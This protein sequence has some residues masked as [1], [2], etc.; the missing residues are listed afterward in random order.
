MTSVSIAIKNADGSEWSSTAATGKPAC[1]KADFEI[2]Q[3]SA[4]N[5][6]LVPG[7]NQFNSAGTAG[8]G[9]KIQL[10]NRDADQENCKGVNVPLAYSAQ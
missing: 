3:P 1:T 2:T 9:A 8:T 6:D 10:V 5:K 7:D 4:L